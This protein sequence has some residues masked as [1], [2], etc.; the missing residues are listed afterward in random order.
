VVASE[1]ENQSSNSPVLSGLLTNEMKQFSRYWCFGV[2]FG[3]ELEL[4][5]GVCKTW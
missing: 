5:G 3:L 4:V 1:E 2:S